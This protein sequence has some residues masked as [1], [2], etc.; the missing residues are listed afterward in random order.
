MS[1]LRKFNE[2]HIGEDCSTLSGEHNNGLFHDCT[3]N[4]LNGLTLKNCDLN[5]SR[6]TTSSIK[7]ALDFTLTLNCHSFNDV[8]LSPL[9]FDLLLV[10]MSTSRGNNEKRRQLVAVVG[11]R[12]WEAIQKVLSGIE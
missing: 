6:F 3:F 8:E 4:K 2:V 11:H 10:L 7:D 5:C 1:E 9:L 12:R